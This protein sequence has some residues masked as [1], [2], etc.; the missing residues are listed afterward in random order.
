[1]ARSCLC[2]V[3]EKDRKINAA[4]EKILRPFIASYAAAETH[5]ER[6]GFR[7]IC[8]ILV[9]LHANISYNKT[10]AGR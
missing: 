7:I 5:T 2:T 6:V 8:E 9:R 3:K 4:I 1:M 10:L